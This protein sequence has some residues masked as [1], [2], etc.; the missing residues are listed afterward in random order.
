MTLLELNIHNII[1][2]FKIAVDRE[3]RFGRYIVTCIQK[4]NYKD[5]L[6]AL[7]KQEIQP[8][9]IDKITPELYNDAI[10]TIVDYVKQC[11]IKPD[12]MF[13][14]IGIKDNK[15]V[16]EYRAEI[17]HTEDF[18]VFCEI[19]YLGYLNK[20]DYESEKTKRLLIYKSK[21]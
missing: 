21:W 12:H 13:S 7:I 3:D 14:Y 1:E 15:I 16:L 6:I 19:Y 2:D 4:P 9:I 17:D 11:F 8:N 5:S 20:E 10:K 18:T